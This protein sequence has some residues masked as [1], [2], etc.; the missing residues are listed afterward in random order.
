MTEQKEYS[1]VDR[2]Q[3]QINHIPDGMDETDL[4]AL[5]GYNLKRSYLIFQSDFRE[6][7]GEGGLSPRVF[8]ALSLV[9]NNPNISQSELA[10]ILGIER[11]GT[12]AIVDELER[13]GYVSRAAVPGDR[14]V[15]ALVAKKKGTNAYKKVSAIVRMH[16]NK[17]MA[18]LSGLEKKTL[19]KLLRKIRTGEK[20]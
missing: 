9:V 16:E 2:Q 7:V 5:I 20:A 13:R 3:K 8:S 4:D 6:S 10:R 17:L 18:H 11:S 15:H 14:R 1:N 19:L 12:V